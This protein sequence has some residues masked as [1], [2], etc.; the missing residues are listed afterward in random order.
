MQFHEVANIF[1]L[2]SD[3]EIQDLASDIRA[4]GLI[5]SIWTYQGKIVDGRNRYT[6]CQI[7]GE[8]PRYQEW[9]GDDSELVAFVLALNLKRRHLDASQ[10]AVIGLAVEKYEA[11]RIA[12][13]ESIWAWNEGA[14][15]GYIQTGMVE[16]K[17]WVSSG[18]D[19][20]CDFCLEMDGR[21]V[22]ISENYFDMGSPIEVSGQTLNLDYEDIAHPPIH[23]NCRCTIS[24]I[25]GG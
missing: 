19:R 11:E 15:Q 21:I 16:S 14:M 3:A 25:L 12:R 6:A 23:C 13:T 18:D 10:R 4:N 20:T 8:E 5:E 22:G 2:M 9:K 24:P 7:A 17:Q 1:P